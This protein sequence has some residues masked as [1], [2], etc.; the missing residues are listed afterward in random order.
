MSWS[1]SLWIIYLKTTLDGKYDQIIIA[2]INFGNQIINA[3]R[4][5]PK[6]V[7]GSHLWSDHICHQNEFLD[8][9]LKAKNDQLIFDIKIS[10]PKLVFGSHLW[11]DQI[12]HKK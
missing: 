3:T 4:S 1:F 5:N 2:E 10:Y 7:L 11:F 9:N 8:Y 6:L 12:C